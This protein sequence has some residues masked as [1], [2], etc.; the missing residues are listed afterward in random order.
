MIDPEKLTADLVNGD[1]DNSDCSQF[2]ANS[3]VHGYETV[4]SLRFKCKLQIT[5]HYS[6]SFI[7]VPFRT[8]VRVAMRCVLHICLQGVHYIISS[9]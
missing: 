5:K 6:V 3:G 1:P 2:W 9:S 4:Q 8:R 7:S